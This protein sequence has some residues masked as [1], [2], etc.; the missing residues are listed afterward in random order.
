MW[1]KE[2]MNL[3]VQPVHCNAEIIKGDLLNAI[4][5]NLQLVKPTQ[6]P[7]KNSGEVLQ[8]GLLSLFGTRINL[9]FDV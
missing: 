4:N 5:N 1:Q 3:L 8:N 9:T 7:I 6:L 2:E